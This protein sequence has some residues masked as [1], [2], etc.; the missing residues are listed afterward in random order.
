[1]DEKKISLTKVNVMLTLKLGHYIFSS[2]R[3]QMSFCSFEGSVGKVLC[4]P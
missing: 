1:M 2:L 3:M 4:D